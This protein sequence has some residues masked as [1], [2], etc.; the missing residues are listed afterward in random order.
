MA[1]VPSLCMGVANT[2]G[3]HGRAAWSHCRCWLHTRGCVPCTLLCAWD[4]CGAGWGE[5]C[6]IAQTCRRRWRWPCDIHTVLLGTCYERGLGV[7]TEESTGK[8]MYSSALP[9]L[10][11]PLQW[12]VL[13][14][15]LFMAVECL[16]IRPRSSSGIRAAPGDC[17][18]HCRCQNSAASTG[19]ARAWRRMRPRVS[20]SLRAAPRLGILVPHA[21]SV[22]T[23]SIAAK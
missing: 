17:A 11:I 16:R 2:Q 14:L 5:G 19:A 15:V 3:P 6:G 13:F 20:G 9:W 18:Y 22:S 23:M 8:Y 21:A 10:E 12:L 7:Q 1:F 4:Q